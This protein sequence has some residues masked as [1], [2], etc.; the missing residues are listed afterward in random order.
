MRSHWLE[1]GTGTA[2]LSAEARQVA[3]AFE[4]IFGDQFL[5][6]GAWGDPGLY[7]RHA[8][9]RRYAVVAGTRGPGVDFVS[10]PE[11]LAVPTDSIDAVFL[12]HILETTDDPHALLREVD[13]IL[14][15][16]GHVVVTG[17]NP[18]GWWGVR[19]HLSRQRFPTGCRRMLSEHRVRDWLQLLDCNVMPA[20]FHHIAAPVYRQ[21]LPATVHSDDD[22]AGS[23]GWPR[24]AAHFRRWNPLASAY[25]LMARK[26][27]FT[28]TLIRPVVR[29]R[30]QLVGGLVN[31]TTRNAA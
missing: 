20:R 21:S 27:V 1:S 15:P 31:P 9:T 18:W 29:P 12:P 2:L 3:D 6:I 23:G 30:R 7:R 22:P 11:D 5:Q 28:L 10:L 26:E 25:L 19:H 14:R 17:F 4:S 16:D 24:T 13:R 8:R